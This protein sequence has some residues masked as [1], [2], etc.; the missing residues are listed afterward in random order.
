M[1]ISAGLTAYNGIQNNFNR[2]AENTQ[3]IANPNSDNQ[4]VSQN[5]ID[6]K[7]T[8]TDIEALV[9]VLKTEDTLIG[10]LLDIKA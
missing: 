7:M 5:L 3:Q 1:E 6:N 10:Q 2:L 4:D 9:K 8:Q